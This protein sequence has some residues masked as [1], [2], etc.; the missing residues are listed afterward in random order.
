M[1]ISF[2]V[3]AFAV[4][5]LVCVPIARAA[6]PGG[7]NLRAAVAA[8]VETEFPSLL[9][10]YTDLHRNPELSLMEERTAGVIARDRRIDALESE[11]DRLSVR[12][13]ALRA[14][15]ANDLRD[16]IAALKIVSVVERIGDYA[17]NIAKFLGVKPTDRLSDVF[18]PTT[19]V[20]A[21]FSPQQ[22]TFSPQDVIEQAYKSMGSNPEDVIEKA[23]AELGGK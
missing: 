3:R 4:C 10:L 19:R 7:E 23:F 13:L 17:K 8:K 15:M 12:V 22:T 1:M 21:Q 20:Q 9:A 2:L 16:V 11:V 5:C 18:A 6:S 14:P